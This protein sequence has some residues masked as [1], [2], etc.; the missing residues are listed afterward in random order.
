MIHQQQL[1]VWVA[2][3]Q[4]LYPIKQSNREKDLKDGGNNTIHKGG[5]T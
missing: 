5:G 2:L 3:S 1:L 4:S